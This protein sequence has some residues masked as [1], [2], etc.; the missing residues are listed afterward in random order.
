MESLTGIATVTK[1][2]RM[3][4]IV[5]F[6]IQSFYF[7]VALLHT[8]KLNTVGVGVMPVVSRD[9]PTMLEVDSYCVCVCVRMCVHMCVC[10]RVCMCES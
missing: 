9:A 8:T 6:I 3:S 10:V 1:G 4:R 5:L 2:L 7:Y